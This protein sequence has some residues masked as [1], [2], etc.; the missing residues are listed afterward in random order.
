MKAGTS[1]WIAYRARGRSLLKRLFQVKEMAHTSYFRH[2]LRFSYLFLYIVLF[3]LKRVL[4]FMG[5]NILNQHNIY[6][7][8]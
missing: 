4:N 1:S 6:H 3:P 2:V 7:Y 5:I 8:E